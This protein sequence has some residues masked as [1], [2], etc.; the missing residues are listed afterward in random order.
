MTIE[1]VSR[2]VIRAAIDPGS[3]RSWILSV[4]EGESGYM[5]PGFFRRNR[6]CLGAGV[7]VLLLG[8]GLWMKFGKKARFGPKT[9]GM[10]FYDGILR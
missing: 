2:N 3:G 5:P 8:L 6:Y 4:E 9:D 10:S 1:D 7:L